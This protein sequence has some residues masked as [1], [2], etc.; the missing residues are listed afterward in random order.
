LEE[1][2]AGRIRNLGFS[3]HGDYAAFQWC[4]DNHAKYRWDFALIQLN[5]IDWKYAERLNSR[6]TNAEKLYNELTKRSIPVVVM[7]PLLGG[8]L[9]KFDY[10]LSKHLSPIDPERSFASWAFRF[11]ASKPNVMTVLS[12]MTKMEHIEENIATFA[13]LKAMSEKELKALGDAAVDFVNS[14]F[15]QCNKCNYCMPCPYGIDIPSVLTFRNDYL[16][17]SRRKRF[18]AK[19]I[20]S[21]YED[22]IPEP[23]RRAE[24]CTGCGRCTPHCPQQFDVSA[25]VVKIAAVMES[26]KDEAY[27]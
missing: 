1:R 15:V 10:A 8:R 26:V 12:G 9:A 23:L 2:A 13:S 7:E 18:S 14:D 24:H 4:M 22:L 16:S 5:Y 3:F 25:E 6:N 11:C 19:E 21:R 27:R 20:L 17:N